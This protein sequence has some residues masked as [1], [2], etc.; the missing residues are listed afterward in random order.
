MRK[1]KQSEKEKKLRNPSLF[2]LEKI[3]ALIRIYT[4]QFSCFESVHRI[5]ARRELYLVA[6]NILGPLSQLRS[7]SLDTHI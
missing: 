7:N 5:E 6:I 4:S 3:S 2:D 1:K